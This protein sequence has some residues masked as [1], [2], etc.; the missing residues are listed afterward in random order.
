MPTI[1]AAIDAVEAKL[2]DLRRLVRERTGRRAPR[3][4]TLSDS[5]DDPHLARANAETLET[6]KCCNGDG[7]VAPV[8][9]ELWA[10]RE[11]VP[12]GQ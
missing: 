12:D 7:V 6:C 1:E 9:M 11:A 8:E 2:G 10:R 3:V 5:L 4:Q